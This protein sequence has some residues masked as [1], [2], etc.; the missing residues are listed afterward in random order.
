MNKK[1]VLN[2]NS[3]EKEGASLYPWKQVRDTMELLVIASD[4]NFKTYASVG[5]VFETIF[6]DSSRFIFADFLGVWNAQ[7]YSNLLKTTVRP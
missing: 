2:P 6:W 5:K 3:H 7:Y 4:K 1:L